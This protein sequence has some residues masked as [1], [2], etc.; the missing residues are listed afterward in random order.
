VRLFG[1]LQ[2]RFPFLI[3]GGKGTQMIPTLTIARTVERL[4][5]RF[6]RE[7]F[8]V[9]ERRMERKTGKI[10]RAYMLIAETPIGWE[11]GK[12][13]QRDTY[14]LQKGFEYIQTGFGWSGN[15]PQVEAWILVNV[16]ANGRIGPKKTWEEVYE[17]F[18]FYMKGKILEIIE[19]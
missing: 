2:K 5:T 17:F 12:G 8:G 3:S 9:L 18:E 11:V 13:T 7:Y 15:E 1:R 19:V 10:D 6:Q 14:A 16:T 4:Q